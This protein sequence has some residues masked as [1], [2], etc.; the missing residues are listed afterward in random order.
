VGTL[1]VCPTEDIAAPLDEV[2]SLLVD[3]GKLD[4][5]WDAK[6]QRMRP[7]GTMVP[8]QLIDAAPRG[9]LKKFHIGLVVKDVDRAQHRLTFV[10]SLPLGITDDVTISCMSLGA[11]RCR[12]SFG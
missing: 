4:L 3:P 8:G 9:L 12:V 10:A 1:S 11:S 5:W 7:V 6:L 2:W